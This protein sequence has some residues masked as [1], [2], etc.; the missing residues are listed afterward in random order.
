MNKL[1]A[2]A[3]SLSQARMKGGVV[4]LSAAAGIDSIE[5]AYRVQRIAEQ[6]SGMA[7][8]GWKVGATSK[9]AQQVLNT[10]EPVTAPIFVPLCFQ[11]PCE[12]AIFCGQG[13][14]VE[15]EFG[16]RFSRELPARDDV[17][18]M[19][20]VLSAVDVLVPVIEVIGSRFKGGFGHIGP[21][22]LVAD[23]VAHTALVTGPEVTGWQELDLTSQSVTLFKN[24]KRFAEGT[25]ADV[26]GSPLLVLEWIANHL[27]RRGE[28]IAAGEI[29][30]TGTCTGIS[31]V[32]P[33]DQLVADFGD[34]G[35]VDLR[36]V[37]R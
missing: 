6:L 13:A 32:A 4:P 23:M 12:V 3:N 22:R 27:S 11:S 35:T 26:F 21:V 24:G 10:K 37:E 18:Y 33:G 31:P 19:E 25:G 34:I 29:I 28:S 36:I 8:A 7:R 9:T 17:Y 20:E 1:E 14:S 30:S 2:L 15:S 16:F 5:T